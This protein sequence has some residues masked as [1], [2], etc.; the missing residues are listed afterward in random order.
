MGF[1]FKSREHKA[2]KRAV[3]AAQSN[4]EKI[5]EARS[6]ID[7]PNLSNSERAEFYRQL[8][9][10]PRY[11]NQRDNSKNPDSTCNLTSMAMAFEGLG[12]DVGDTSSKQGEENLY[13]DF[14]KKSRSRINE[15]HRADFARDKGLDTNH[16]ETPT[17][18]N[19]GE[20]QAWFKKNVLPHLQQGASAT[21][22]IK[23][24]SFRHVVRL[25][26]VE[27]KGL[28][29]DDPWGQAVGNKGGFGYA[30]VNPKT[31]DTKGDQAGNG[32]DSFLDWESV[33]KVCS[34]RYVQLYNTKKPSR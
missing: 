8:S 4:P 34:D 19:G 7:N 22:G 23:S 31:R 15:D 12:M 29:V 25:Q 6:L 9:E 1:L 2:A 10:A 33:A 11:R 17:F 26:W 3:K 13:A 21:L 18:S 14:Y 20:A 30:S 24:G 27:A 5:G 28:R 32:D 16:V